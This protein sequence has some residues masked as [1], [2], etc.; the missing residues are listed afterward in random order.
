M[1]KPTSVPKIINSKDS[2]RM[3]SSATTTP[4][5]KEYDALRILINK[6]VSA[7]KVVDAAQKEKERQADFLRNL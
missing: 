2:L 6:V 1:T 4:D 5:N 7:S 3:I